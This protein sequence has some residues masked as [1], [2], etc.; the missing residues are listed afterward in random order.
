MA[1]EN[2][3]IKRMHRSLQMEIQSIFNTLIEKFEATEERERKLRTAMIFEA[4][5]RLVRHPYDLIGIRRQKLFEDSL[6]AC[7]E[8]ENGRTSVVSTEL[9]KSRLYQCCNKKGVQNQIFVALK[10][11]A[12][13]IVVTFAVIKLKFWKSFGWN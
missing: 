6:K 8:V 13:I 7:L 2:E 4:N 5:G 1:H 3:T 11:V 12:T 10:I 9:V